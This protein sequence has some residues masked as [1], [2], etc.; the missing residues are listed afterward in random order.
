MRHG[1]RSALEMFKSTPKV[2]RS[3]SGQ[4]L[5]TLL[6]TPGFVLR[7]MTWITGHAREFYPFGAD[8][9]LQPNRLKALAELALMLFCYVR[10]TGDSESGPV[11]Q[12]IAI[13]DR[14]QRNQA[15]RELPLRSTDEFVPVCDVY[16]A[17]RLVGRDAPEQRVLLERVLQSGILDYIDRL[18]QGSMEVRLSAESAGLQGALSNVAPQDKLAWI[19]ASILFDNGLAYALTHTIMFITDFGAHPERLDSTEGLRDRLAMLLV[20]YCRER[21]YDLLAELLICWDAAALPSTPLIEGVWDVFLGGQDRWGAF[22]AQA[23]VDDRPSGHD[24]APR[25]SRSSRFFRHYHTTILAVI[26]GSLHERPPAPR[27]VRM[28]SHSLRA[29][30]FAVT[31]VSRFD[32]VRAFSRALAWL[33][34]GRAPRRERDP[35]VLCYKVLAAWIGVSMA[36]SPPSTSQDFEDALVALV[37]CEHAEPLARA[38]APATLKIILASLLLDRG[39]ATPSLKRF[40]KN[41]LFLLRDTPE[42]APIK[43]LPLHEKRLVLYA[44]GLH[45]RPR[46]TNYED[47]IDSAKRAASKGDDESVDDLLLHIECTTELGT[48]RVRVRRQ[49]LWLRQLLAGFAQHALRMYDWTRGCRTLRA[50]GYLALDSG[51]SF[52]ACISYMILHQTTSGAFGFLGREANQFKI[53]RRGKSFDVDIRIPLTTDCLW[54]L[55]ELGNDTRWRLYAALPKLDA[56]K[57][58]GDITSDS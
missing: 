19:P 31:E 48:R 35:N 17:L 30:L 2:T 42:N 18:P 40:L 11:R 13:L 26:A 12:I 20:R 24:E 6:P 52:N 38:T 25:P 37:K 21:N 28:V 55:A 10:L 47:M 8:G 36:A 50:L 27:R 39:E 16:A 4:R 34:G 49:D 43:D 32:V 45:P 23:L 5:K 29:P 53:R 54:T 9:S 3:L 46:L 1:C 56:R 44:V 41:V 22:P 57:L 14:V 33:I 51:A 7:A 15:F 58:T